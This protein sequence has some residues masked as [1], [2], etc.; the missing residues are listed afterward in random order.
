[1][2]EF[3][4]QIVCSDMGTKSIYCTPIYQETPKSRKYK[5]RDSSRPTLPKVGFSMQNY[6]I[7]FS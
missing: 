1:M 4:L 5:L 7:I 6:I 3:K 2:T